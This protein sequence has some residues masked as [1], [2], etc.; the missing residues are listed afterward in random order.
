MEIRHYIKKVKHWRELK[1][2]ATLSIFLDYSLWSISI[3]GQ[4]T[5]QCIDCVHLLFVHSY[6]MNNGFPT[7][8]S[9]GLFFFSYQH[10]SCAKLRSVILA[11]KI[12]CFFPSQ[13]KSPHTGFAENQEERMI[14]CTAPDLLKASKRDPFKTQLFRLHTNLILMHLRHSKL[15]Y[16]YSQC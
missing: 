13:V 10:N 16:P 5:S 2:S 15:F 4:E 14:L 11:T 12:F 6:D 9:T 8:H 1:R 7:I 3:N